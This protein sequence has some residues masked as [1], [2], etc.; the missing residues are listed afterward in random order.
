MASVESRYNNRLWAR[1]T[2]GQTIHT[3]TSLFAAFLD[4]LNIIHTAFGWSHPKLLQ[5]WQAV[6]VGGG[7]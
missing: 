4:S 3:H 2:S 5:L 1:R 7:Q 6:T